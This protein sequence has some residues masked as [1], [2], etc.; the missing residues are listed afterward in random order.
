VSAKRYGD[1][2]SS[3]QRVGLLD[4]RAQRAL[5]A[6]RRAYAVA[7]VGID[8]IN[9]RINGEEAPKAAW[10]GAARRAVVNVRP[11]RMRSRKVFLYGEAL[12]AQASA[13]PPSLSM[14]SGLAFWNLGQYRA[15]PFQ[16]HFPLRLLAAFPTLKA[17][18][19]HI[20][21]SP[22]RGRNPNPA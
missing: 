10:S 22:R 11:A 14:A 17:M 16:C 1:R 18:T 21:S 3:G 19:P 12:L 13:S 4:G 9:R 2:V 15:N 8:R 7:K 20:T 6:G 5:A